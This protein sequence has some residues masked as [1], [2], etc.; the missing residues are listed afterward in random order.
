MARRARIPRLQRSFGAGKRATGVL[1]DPS[2]PS[3]WPSQDPPGTQIWPSSGS[4]R[5]PR[6]PDLAS[7]GVLQAPPRPSR[8]PPRGLPGPPGPL[9]EP[10]QGPSQ[11]PSR[12]PGSI[13]SPLGTSDH[14]RT[15]SRR[16]RRRG[17][18]LRLRNP[19]PRSS[20]TSGIT[21]EPYARFS[22]AAAAALLTAVPD[23]QVYTAVCTQVMYTTRVHTSQVHPPVYTAPHRRSP[24][25]DAC[26]AY[27]ARQR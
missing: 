13:R 5:T 19:R 21:S 8:T 7:S 22:A 15:G 6:S 12:T 24:L 25:H 23:R 1:P 18:R 17:R 10:S 14:R 27:T 26:R 11:D 9:P 16:R 20:H 3:I 4:P 2:G